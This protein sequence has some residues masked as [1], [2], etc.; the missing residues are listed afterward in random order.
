MA[1][2]HV[3]R[4]PPA[5]HRLR[6]PGDRRT[7]RRSARRGRVS[8]ASRASSGSSRL[9]AVSNRRGASLPRSAAKEIRARRTSTWARWNSSSGPASA[10]AASVSASSSAPACCFAWAAARARPARRAG[11]SVNTEER[12]RKAAAAAKPPRACARAAE[13]SS[14][15]ATSSSGMAAACARCQARRS[16]SI[17]WIGRLREGAVDLAAL[18]RPGCPVHRRANQRMT[19]HHAGSRAPASRPIR[20]SAPPTRGCRA[21]APPATRAP[22]RRPGRPRPRAT[23]AARHAGASPAAA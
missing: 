18:V 14:S 11:S 6:L 4:R 9:A 13:R 23:G 2:R 10:L 3:P 12:S 8:R 5:E 21:A 16:G 7:G 15:A 19:E 1:A 17:V 22:D 20:R